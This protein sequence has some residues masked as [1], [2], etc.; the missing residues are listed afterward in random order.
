MQIPCLIEL[1]YLVDLQT[2]NKAYLPM[3]VI[4]TTYTSMLGGSDEAQKHIPTLTRQWLKDKILSELPTVTSARQRDRRKTSILYC[5]E[6]CEEDMV[7]SSMMHTSE[8][9]DT[10]MIFKAGK[11]VRN[12]I[13]KFAGEKEADTFFVSSTRDDIPAHLYSLIRWI[14]VGSEEQLQSE[15]RSRAVDRSALTIC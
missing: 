2:R 10:T 14:L 9:E 7:Y 15:M 13:T 3:D 12:S 11:L 5:P 6:A 4:E 1:I 8:M